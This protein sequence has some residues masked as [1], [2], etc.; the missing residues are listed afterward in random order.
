[1]HTPQVNNMLPLLPPLT[2]VVVCAL[3][4]AFFLSPSWRWLTDQNALLQ[5]AVYCVTLF[6]G[7]ARG[8][9]IV[10]RWWKRRKTII[11]KDSQP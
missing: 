11:E 7:I 9:V 10:R 4:L 1:M 6:L 5:T 8:V 3:A 2:D